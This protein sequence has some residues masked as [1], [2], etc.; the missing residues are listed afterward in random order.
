MKN[1]KIS[2]VMPVYN[3]QE[4]LGEAIKSI[5]SQSFRDFEL[6]IVNDGSTDNTLGII[7][8]FKDKRIRVI[9]NV[10]NL[11]LAKTINRGVITAKG[12]YIARCDADDINDK[13]RFKIQVD[14]LDK[15]KNY[16]LVGSNI[17]TIGESS[18]VTGFLKFPE[19]D[20]QIRKIILV[21]NCIVHPS[22]MMRTKVV[23]KVGSYREIFNG[24]AEE[25]DLWFRLM[26]L[27]KFY[28]IQKNLIKRRFHLNVYT[29]KHHYRVEL[30][31]FLVRVV[32]F[33]RYLTNLL[34]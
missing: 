20:F 4:F 33:P 30:L 25:Y 11:G 15:N 17:E 24:G 23:K 5:L 29:K 3:G 1:P 2:V 32:N 34:K 22:V 31:A 13:D 26:N 8:K 18:K 27:G 16:V 9:N 14:F 21:Y 19:K 28:N 6:I 7:E 10:K 12:E